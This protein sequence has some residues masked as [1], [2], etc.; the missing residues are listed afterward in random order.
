MAAPGPRL[1]MVCT[2][3]ICRS[4]TMEGVLRAWAQR[5]G[6]GAHM[7]SAGT[8]GW[9]A[10]EPPDPRTQAA[11]RARGYELGD[12]RARRVRLEDFSRFDLILAADRGHLAQ[13]RALAPREAGR[14]VRLFLGEGELPDPYDGGP[15]GFEAVLD[16]VEARAR[17][18]D[19][20]AG[21][22]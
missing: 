10:G 20:S 11:A 2:G 17:A 3:N 8:E 5:R 6:W 18:W 13:L 9:H 15:E 12:L 16:A 1:L 22:F 19:G 7:D 4:P 14:K 21:F